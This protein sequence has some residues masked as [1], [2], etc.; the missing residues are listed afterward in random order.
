MKA[1]LASMLAIS[2]TLVLVMT[3]CTAAGPTNSASQSGRT[4]GTLRL[5]QSAADL[6]TLDPH[7]AS[8]TQDRSLVDMVFNA[9]IRFKP[10]DGTQFEPD[11]ATALP[12]PKTEGGKQTWTFALRKGV[13]CQ[14]TEGVPS[15]ELT[16]DDIVYSLQKSADKSRS[17]YAGDYSGMKFE[18]VDPAT[19]KVTLDAALSKALLYPKLANYS[20]GYIMCRKAAEKLGAD[21]LKTHPVGTGPFTFKSYSP[22]EKVELVANEAYFRGKPQLD[23]VQFLYMPDLSSRELG[24]LGGQLD[25]ANGT[26]DNAWVQ[27]MEANPD[28]KVDIFGVGEVVTIFFNSR[29]A[30]LDKL[31][32]RQAIAYALD[33][34]EFQAL[35]G[36]R[37]SEQVFSPVPAQFMPGGLTQQEAAAKGVE[38]KT[39]REKAKRLLADAGFPNGFTLSMVTSE[40]PSYR[41]VYE[42][43]QAQLAKVGIKIEL[44]VV[45]HTSMHSTIRQDTNPI[46]VYVAFRPNADV[47][48]TQFFHSDAI[49]VTGKKP[50]TNFSHYASIDTLI[51]Q[52]RSEPDTAKQTALWKET[53]TKILQDMAAYPV[54]FTNQ[55]YARRKT[56]DYGHELKSVLALYP[57]IDET[58]R[59]TKK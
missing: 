11:L 47:Y 12:E 41:V 45:D 24:L 21:G 5:G 29:I 28:A 56:V 58:T 43:M 6:G 50:N 25:V 22:K 8:G 18:A 55:V 42:S 4:G 37:V 2:M 57:G 26:A 14:P 34:A 10:G 52:A 9:L 59:L 32:V 38:Y 7:F 40:L 30:P 13:M 44:K 15:Y 48:L 51:D 16:S 54:M 3:A 27:K 19:V 35:T 31:P 23:G 36:S 20:G 46:V 33:R 39:D 49:V 17:A 1:K 53:Q